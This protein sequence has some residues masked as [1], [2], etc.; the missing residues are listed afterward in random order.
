MAALIL[1]AGPCTRPVVHAPAPARSA[2]PGRPPLC[3]HS[4][5]AAR[6]AASDTAAAQATQPPGA[7]RSY[8][9]LWYTSQ[10]LAA[11]DASADIES[12]L[13]KVGLGVRKGARA[14]RVGC[15][16]SQRS[17]RESPDSCVRLPASPAV[18][19]NNIEQAE[20]R[21]DDQAGKRPELQWLPRGT[22]AASVRDSR[23]VPSFDLLSLDFSTLF[24]EVV[25]LLSASVADLLP[26]SAH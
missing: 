24:E 6:C 23:G 10:A 21:R 17:A 8:Q 3:R 9:G 2:A 15:V 5:A 12:D 4:H 13:L 22:E 19:L 7:Q 1:P 11:Y 25:D 26:L 18:Q 16:L 20:S 14:A